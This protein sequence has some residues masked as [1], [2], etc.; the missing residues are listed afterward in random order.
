MWNCWRA[1]RKMLSFP[2][3]VVFPSMATTTQ[4][5]VKFVYSIPIPSSVRVLAAA[6]ALILFAFL[7]GIPL[8]DLGA[9]RMVETF[10]SDTVAW[11]FLGATVGSLMAFFIVLAFPP[12]SWRAELE[13]EQDRIRLI[14]RPVLSWIDEPAIDMEFGPRVH[15]ILLCRGSRFN[16]PFGFRIILRAFDMPDREFKVETGDDLA[17]ADTRFLSDGITAATGLPVRLIERKIRKNGTVR[18]GIWIPPSR[19]LPSTE[20]AR[21]IAVAFPFVSGAVTGYLQPGYLTVAIVWI[22]LWLIQ[23]LVLFLYNRFLRQPRTFVAFNWFYSLF[24][25]AVEYATTFAYVS[26]MFHKG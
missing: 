9:A 6:V 12:R 17:L 2:G 22:T 4:A 20:I 14:P 7:F 23:T 25:F 13:I 5:G 19:A 26:Y 16:S 15:E 21:L 10:R 1:N 24:N 11:A 3:S 8:V 18:E